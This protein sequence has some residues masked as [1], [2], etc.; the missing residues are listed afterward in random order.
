VDQT[1]PL[2]GLSPGSIPVKFT[3][4]NGPAATGEV[5][6]C[7]GVTPE[8][9]KTADQ[10]RAKLVENLLSAYD[11]AC[12]SHDDGEAEKLAKAALLLDPTCFR[13]DHNK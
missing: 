13:R 6:R 11:A 4:V 1:I 3:R 7:E 10:R 8:P 2:N 9:S 5:L 12:A